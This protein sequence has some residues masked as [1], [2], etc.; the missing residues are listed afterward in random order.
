MG[1]AVMVQEPGHGVG[2]AQ[3]VHETTGIIHKSVI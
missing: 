2:P 3:V 1:N